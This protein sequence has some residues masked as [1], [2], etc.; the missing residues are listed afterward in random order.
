MTLGTPP[1]AKA[2]RARTG[3]RHLA[4]AALMTVAAPAA[5]DPVVIAAFGDSLVHGWGVSEAEGFVPQL[6]AWLRAN[7]APEAVVVNAGVSG[8]TSAGGL[9]R[10]AATL[11]PEVDAVIVE[12]GANDL[13][14]GID[15]A[16]TRANLDGILAA[17]GARDLPVLLV[18]VPAIGDFGPERRAAFDA[19]YVDLAAEH[20]TLLYRDFFGGI[21]DLA[22]L[23]AARPLM[24]AD[25]IHPNAAGVAANVAAI[26]PAALELVVAAQ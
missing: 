26:G 5:A 1:T 10:V 14:R 6:Q 4:V 22:D 12:L 25:M 20:G 24:Q 19:I 21:G 13:L 23:D 9:A 11:T 16:E 3:L 7:G 17:I 15:P 2:M 8:D 18:G